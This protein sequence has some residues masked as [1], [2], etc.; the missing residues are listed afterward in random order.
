MREVSQENPLE[1]YKVHVLKDA[2]KSWDLPI[3]GNKTALIAR[4]RQADPEG[5]R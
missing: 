2:L 1:E 3:Y 4:I 5:H